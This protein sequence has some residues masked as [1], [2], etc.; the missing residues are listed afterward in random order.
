[1]QGKGTTEI[2]LRQGFGIQQM[3]Q[4]VGSG[5][6][7]E[8]VEREARERRSRLGGLELGHLAVLS[9]SRQQQ[10]AKKG[11]SVGGISSFGHKPGHVSL[12]QTSDAPEI[13]PYKAHR[14]GNPRSSLSWQR[15]LLGPSQ[16]KAWVVTL[17]V[18]HA[19]LQGGNPRLAGKEDLSFEL[20]GTLTSGIRWCLKMHP[21]K[22]ICVGG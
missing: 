12:S 9:L 16:W 2:K 21:L 11:I 15:S 14:T 17:T 8:D 4:L 5:V 18:S 6:T 10:G 20:W 1:M 22:K 13:K 19:H 3:N 7:L